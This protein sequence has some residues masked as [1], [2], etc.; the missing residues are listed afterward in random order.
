MGIPFA[1]EA[2]LQEL[3]QKLNASS[4]YASAAKKWEGDLCF[5]V[6][7]G[8]GIEQDTY[9]YMDLWHGQSRGVQVTTTPI[10]SEFTITAPLAT[11]KR[12]IQGKLD[13]I[14]GLMGRQ[15]KLKGPMAKIMKAPKA[16]IE[17]VN[18][19]KSI[20]TQWPN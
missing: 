12:V 1:T 2:W 19:A 15:L 4:A 10:N 17:L 3:H 7:A 5:I 9:L 20:D 8:A 13:P 14:R 18:C 16:A 11:W 6:S